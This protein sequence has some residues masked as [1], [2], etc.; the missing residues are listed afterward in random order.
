MSLTITDLDNAKLDTDTISEVAMVGTTSDT[1]ANRDGVVIDTLQGRLKKLGYLPPVAYAAAIAFLVTDNVKTIDRNGV[2]YAPIPSALPF[3][4]SG[5]WGGDDESKFFVIQST[6]EIADLQDDVA[7][8]VSL[9]G[10]P[11]NSTNL[12]SFPGDIIPDN[13]DNKAAMAALEGAIESTLQ[14]NVYNSQ[15]ITSNTAF[16]KPANAVI[17]KV[18]IVSGG[19]GGAGASYREIAGQDSQSGAGGGSGAKA[20]FWTNAASAT[21]TIGSGGSG[22]NGELQPANATAGANGGTSSFSAPGVA[23]VTCSGGRGGYS[24][25]FGTVDK[26]N[27]G[28]EGGNVID[29]GG[30]NPAAGFGEGGSGQPGGAAIVGGGSGGDV[31]FL[32]GGSPG[33]NSGINPQANGAGGK[34]GFVKLTGGAEAADGD[35]GQDGYCL[36]EWFS[37]S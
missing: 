27:Q 26:R 7:D 29:T 12:G 2:I 6:G 24:F 16:V 13:S 28:G 5:T 31:Q 18:T 30:F 8:L 37:V 14:G 4:T 11:E 9:S 23:V 33:G 19:G 17:Y 20:V 10:V 35:D 21:I 36:I 1:T 15:L 32:A 34:G 3:T 22:G 25:N